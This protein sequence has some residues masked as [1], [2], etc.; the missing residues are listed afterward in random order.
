MATITTATAMYDGDDDDDDHN[1]DYG[2]DETRKTYPNSCRHEVA[3]AC[4]L[5]AA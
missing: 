5:C 2:D 4:A 3:H 1:D